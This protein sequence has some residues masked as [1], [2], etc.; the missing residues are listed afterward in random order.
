MLAEHEKKHAFVVPIQTPMTKILSGNDESM[1]LS[2]LSQSR[3][4][5]TWVRCYAKVDHTSMLFSRLTAAAKRAL[6]AM[7]Y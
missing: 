6:F 5:L 7:Q 4:T 3:S 1:L 2:M